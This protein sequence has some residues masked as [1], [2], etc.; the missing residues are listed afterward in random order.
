MSKQEK[1]DAFDPNGV[2][3]TDSGIFGL[4]FEVDEAEVVILPVPWDVTTSYRD[5]TSNGPETILWA[6]RQVDLY[7]SG[8]KDA[9]KMGIAMRDIPREWTDLNKHYRK[10]ANSVIEKLEKGVSEDDDEVSGLITEI[11]EQ[12][13]E[14]VEYVYS[15]AKTQ[16]ENGKLVAVLGGDHSTPLGLI[17]ALAEKHE[18][19]GILQIDAHADLRDSYEGFEYSHASIMHNAVQIE[20][21]GKLVAVGLRDVCEQEMDAIFNSN[22]RIV[23]YF[24]EQMKSKLF[25]GETWKSICDSIISELPQKVYISFDIDGLEPSLC[26]NTGTPVPGGLS[27]EQAIYLIKN[28]VESGRTIIGFDLCE[29]SPSES[30][31]DTNVGARLLF[32]LCNQFGLS[33]GRMPE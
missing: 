27:F 19:F 33:N 22:D 10:K 2:G 24:D 5:G 16:M 14:L 23:G 26:P 12:C 21:V 28:V 11:N 15:R 31:W 30:E 17:R 4:P 9:W 20:Q 8:I 13:A 7:Y 1:I 18:E 3:L 25:Q 6:S 29:V 32:H